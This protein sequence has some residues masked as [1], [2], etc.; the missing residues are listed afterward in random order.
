MDKL[1]EIAEMIGNMETTIDKLVKAVA[2]LTK[3]S[4]KER[5]ESKRSANSGFNKPIKVSDV[6]QEFLGLATDEMISRV[7]ATR[8]ITAYVKKNNLQDPSNG[9]V[10]KPDDKLEGVLKAQGSEV[11][12]FNLQKLLKDHFIS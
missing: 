1:N 4:K 9:R 5:G 2:K 11:T 3:A 8:R 12:W 7:E 6:L 10:I